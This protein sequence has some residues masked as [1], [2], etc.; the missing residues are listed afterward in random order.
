MKRLKSITTGLLFVLT[1]GLSNSAAASYQDWWWNPAQSGMGVNIG[2]Q[3]NT[4]FAAWNLYGDDGKATFLSFSGT[5]I[6]TIRGDTVDGA[7]YR[8]TGPSPGL[9]MDNKQPTAGAIACRGGRL[10]VQIWLSAWRRRFTAI[11]TFLLETGSFVD[12]HAIT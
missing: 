6:P 2:Q 8:N 12:T 4:I 7:L 9:A 1:L 10:E 3:D 11:G 5:I